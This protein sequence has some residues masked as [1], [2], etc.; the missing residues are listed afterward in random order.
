MRAAVPLAILLLGLLAPASSAQNPPASGGW[1]Q[2]DNPNDLSLGAFGQNLG[3][4]PSQWHFSYLDIT[5]LAIEDPD[6]MNLVFRLKVA[7]GF[8][9]GPVAGSVPGEYILHTIQFKVPGSAA[10]GV[11]QAIS[12]GR[13]DAPMPTAPTWVVFCT[14]VTLRNRCENPFGGPP[15]LLE[16]TI[17]EGVL[18]MPVPKGLMTRDGAHDR[19]PAKQQLP[20]E[21]DAGA[22]L[23]NIVVSAEGSYFLNQV[24]FGV[25][26]GRPVSVSD[27]MPDASPAP[28]YVLANGAAVQDL[29]MKVDARG[30]ILGQESALPVLLFNKAA[31]KRLVNL[32][33]RHTNPDDAG[34]WRVS[35]TP[36][37]TI[38]SQQYVNASL[39]VFPPAAANPSKPGKILITASILN[40][41]RRAMYEAKLLPTPPLDRAH[42]TYFV[43]G[44]RNQWG[45]AI[46]LPACPNYFAYLNRVEE[47]KSSADPQGIRMQ[48]G[49]FVSET[50]FS[51]SVAT[52]GFF[53]I[54]DTIPNAARLNP[55]API[56]LHL[57]V[58]APAAFAA[59]AKVQLTTDA[60]LLGIK[61]GPVTFKQGANGFDFDLKVLNET[62]DAS[63]GGVALY[64][65]VR[66]TGADAL[67]A[68]ASPFESLVL[69]PK[70]SKIQLDLERIV[71]E[72]PPLDA[73]KA[74]LAAA[75]DRETFA[76]PGRTTVF[77][78][79]LRNEDQGPLRVELKVEGESAP[80]PVT[81]KPG[82]RFQL[83]AGEAVRLGVAVT[84]ADAAKEGDRLSFR[85][86]AFVPDKQ[87]V[88]SGVHLTT[89]AT[90]GIDI[91]NET[92]V[93]A[94]EDAKKLDEPAKST[95]G[96]PF[97]LVGAVLAVGAT[98]VRRRRA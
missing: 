24:G 36:T 89:I 26:N 57:E 64:I 49:G 15:S 32:T 66:A 45:N 52:R 91:E 11:V 37:I 5:G 27:R 53:G 81:I 23:E 41:G 4:A 7:G 43:H 31:S 16:F 82:V 10:Y 95:P 46:C 54:Y 34:A 74:I 30:A 19:N 94:A 76:N 93:S 42:A 28:P 47:D 78:I 39:R 3:P 56:K 50:R 17:E 71:E 55:G 96:L 60:G 86:I 79:D 84:V 8:R 2:S 62:L 67:L 70:A 97:G 9:P 6:E 69:L 92:F 59:T 1:T 75:E 51:T 48:R 65:E 20:V 40:E 85:L 98:F 80:W 18:V 14:M 83:K 68:G 29:V 90:R 88:A 22:V 38:G 44:T 58:E 73:P 33:V 35:I 87:V 25:L 21:I 61:E 72:L 13:I 63:D 77:E 12:D